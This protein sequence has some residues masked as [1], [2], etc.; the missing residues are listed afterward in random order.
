MYTAY[1]ARQ[2][3]ASVSSEGPCPVPCSL[4]VNEND[5]MVVAD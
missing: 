4:P 1:A 3:G 5:Q 2:N